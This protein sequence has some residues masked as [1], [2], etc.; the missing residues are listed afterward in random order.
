MKTEERT[1]STQ[2]DDELGTIDFVVIEFPGSRFNGELGTAL[3]DLV[4]QGLVRIIDLVFIHKGADG[5]VDAVELA[6]AEPEEC[7]ALAGL[8]CDVPGL[9]ADEDVA[10]AAEALEPGSSAAL[11]IWENVWAAPFA[12]AVRQSGGE[13]VA[14]G[15]I[16]LADVLASIETES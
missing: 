11:I 8:E 5:V 13:L 1:M 4:R 12:R 14:S 2:L 10:A 16:P 6:D 9:L 3:I 7:G 15:R